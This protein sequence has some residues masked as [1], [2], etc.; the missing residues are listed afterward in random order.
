M[1]LRVHLTPDSQLNNK[2]EQMLAS[3]RG[4][5]KALT[6]CS[7]QCKLVHTL[8]IC[9]PMVIAVLFTIAKYGISLGACQ[10]MNG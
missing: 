7:W 6:H 10:Q 4:E 3:T 5:G 1:T 8:K 2:P 9:T